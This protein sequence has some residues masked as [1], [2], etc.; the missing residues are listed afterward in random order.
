MRSVKAAQRKWY[1]ET[2]RCGPW[3]DEICKS[4]GPGKKG[5]VLHGHVLRS[6]FKFVLLSNGHG[7]DNSV[8]YPGRQISGHSTTIVSK[9][10]RRR[11]LRRW[12]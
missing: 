9:F 5:A 8:S 11:G 4:G 3:V 7:P 2:H 1:V 6:H 12:R 10:V